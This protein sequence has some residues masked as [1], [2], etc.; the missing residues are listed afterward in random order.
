[1]KPVRTASS[2]FTYLGPTPD[3][4]DLPCQRVRPGEIRS[5]WELSE[6]ERD[7]VAAGGRIELAI[8]AEPIPPVSLTVLPHAVGR[9]VE[10]AA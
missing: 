9:P 7:M 3:V 4:G 1:M 10:E 5:V 8:Y 2:N 6:L